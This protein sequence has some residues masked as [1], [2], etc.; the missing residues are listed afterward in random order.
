M[1]LCLTKT[2]FVY[3]INVE[4]KMSQKIFED[5]EEIHV[6]NELENNSSINKM[7]LS[8]RFYNIE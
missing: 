3:A 1:I 8:N 2:V 7:P 4:N 6:K 5:L